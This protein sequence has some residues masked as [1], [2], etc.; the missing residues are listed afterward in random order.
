MRWAG[1]ALAL[2]ASAG[3]SKL[4]DGI[5][6]TPGRFAGEADVRRAWLPADPA[7]AI[8]VWGLSQ[9]LDAQPD[10]SCPVI[11]EVTDG[12]LIHG[13][14][15]D[16]AGGRWVGEAERS[17][18]DGEVALFEG[19]GVTVP[20][21]AIAS[22]VQGTRRVSWTLDGQVTW[23]VDADSGD[24]IV[25][26]ELGVDYADDADEYV[27]WM[28]LQI[29]IGFDGGRVTARGASGTVGVEDWGLAELDV[30]AV[31][32]GEN[33]DCDYPAS[34]RV[35]MAG[36]NSA[37]VEFVEGDLLCPACPAWSIAGAEGG[38]LCDPT[39]GL[40]LPNAF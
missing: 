11:E 8:F 24:Q 40:V 31:D 15:T 14:C 9:T 16:A 3:C 37:A 12:Y 23:S 4:P 39:P 20:D 35:G 5:P 38:E 6:D 26:T 25:A 21:A 27:A 17:S 28:D 2:V 36:E 30:G 22:D 34:G 7:T 1:A 10:Q 33:A 18:L 29:R 32:F 19:F 13:G